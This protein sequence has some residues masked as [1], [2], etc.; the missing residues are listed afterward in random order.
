MILSAKIRFIIDVIEGQILIMNRKMK[1]VEE[2]LEKLNYYKYENS[3]NYLVQM[4]ISQ[5]TMEKK[6]MLEREVQKLKNEIERLKNKSLIEIWEEELLEL[7]D[8][9]I[10]EE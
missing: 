9:I 6:E 5:L 2:Q 3:Y 10:L 1:D 4:P 8:K 7:K